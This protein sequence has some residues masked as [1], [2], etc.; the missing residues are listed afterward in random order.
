MELSLRDD[1]GFFFMVVYV[2]IFP[3]FRFAKGFVAS[4]G[5]LQRRAHLG[6]GRGAEPTS[7]S[8]PP[9]RTQLPGALPLPP[10]EL[11]ACRD[12]CLCGNQERRAEIQEIVPDVGKSHH[13]R[14]DS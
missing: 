4:M 5:H 14:P 8:P 6:L 1:F 12:F 10:Q 13:N 11:F 9:T 7:L 2:L 3:A